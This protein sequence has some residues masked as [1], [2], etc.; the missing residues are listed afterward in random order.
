[1][2]TASRPRSTASRSRPT[3]GPVAGNL[4]APRLAGAWATLVY[5]VATVLLAYP[6]LAGRFLVN[7]N[8]DQY[9]AG[10]ALREF[11]AQSLRTGHGFPMWNPYL[12]GG[13]PFVASM[14]GDIFYATFRCG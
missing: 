6:A 10:Y 13:M 7:A 2:A 4:P 12:F 1:M 3:A 14:N 9:I 5:A 8:S 11:A